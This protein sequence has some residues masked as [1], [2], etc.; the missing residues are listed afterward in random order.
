MNGGNG[1]FNN[2]EIPLA[3][4]KSE[5]GNY[6][7][8][9]YDADSLQIIGYGKEIGADGYAENASDAVQLAMGLMG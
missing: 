9:I 5:S 4:Q 8:R 6:K 2:F 7:I 1:S 3:L